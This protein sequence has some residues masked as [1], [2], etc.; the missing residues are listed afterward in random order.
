MYETWHSAEYNS[1]MVECFQIC[2]SG[3]K[4]NG[5]TERKTKGDQ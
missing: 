2:T 4:R 3:A 5:S 1:P